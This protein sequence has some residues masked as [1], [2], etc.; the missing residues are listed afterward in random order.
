MYSK[1]NNTWQLKKHMLPNVPI[2]FIFG[3]RCCYEGCSHPVC[4]QGH[5]KKTTWF[6][7]GLSID[8]L[9][10]PVADPERLFHFTSRAE[11]KGQCSVYFNDEV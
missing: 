7:G 1:F 3:L 8:F 11:C 5:P 4:K 9:P 10:L 2:K 6:S